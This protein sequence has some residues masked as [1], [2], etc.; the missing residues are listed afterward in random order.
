MGRMTRTGANVS[1]ANVKDAPYS[2]SN[3]TSLTGPDTAL[4]I[5]SDVYIGNPASVTSGYIARD[6]I[7]RDCNE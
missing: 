3:K 1:G 7:I 6:R 4:A 2:T 5:L